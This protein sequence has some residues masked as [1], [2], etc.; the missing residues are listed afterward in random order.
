MLG[1]DAAMYLKELRECQHLVPASP[2]EK[3][4]HYIHLKKSPKF[5]ESFFPIY[6]R[7]P[8]R[9]PPIIAP[10]MPL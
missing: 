4:S 2:E 6:K 8:R 10:Q 5:S 3:K 7:L 1:R 9:K